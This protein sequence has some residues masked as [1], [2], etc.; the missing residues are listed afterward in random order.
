[1]ICLQRWARALPAALVLLVWLVPASQ[2]VTGDALAQGFPNRPMKFIVPFPPGG[3][4]DA[5][6]RIFAAEM[7]ATL[8]QPVLVENRPGASGAIGVDAIAK[9][10]PDGYTMGLS[11]TGP[12][13]LVH[14][15]GPRP[16]FTMKDLIVVGHAGLVELIVVGRPGLPYN[17]IRE[18]VAVAKASPGK[19][20]YATSGSGSPPHL[21]FEYLNSLA[22]IELLHIPYKGDAPA[23]TDLMGN[24]VDL[25]ILGVPG[26][27]V[28][29]KAGKIKPIAMTATTRSVALPEVPTVAESGV[30]GYDAAP[31]TLFVVP[32]GTP[33]PIVER[34]NAALNDALR[35]PSV[36][37]R[38][39]TFGITPVVMT[40]A[41]ATEFL[42]RQTEKW[43]KVIR[44]AKVPTVQ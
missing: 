10:A 38:F 24:Q 40:P 14:I 28:Q 5:A 23:L 2:L 11:G 29:I 42:Q 27:V 34:L 41:A 4:T 26:A 1:M 37:E 12:S 44:D 35:K 31:F 25:A 16:G 20:S 8:G 15:M 13:V 9:S 18:I 30:P 33:A 17:S 43:A 39:A 6:G 22:G 19:I 7:A 32:A 3:S 36:V 21:S